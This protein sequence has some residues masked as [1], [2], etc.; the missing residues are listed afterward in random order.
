[1]TAE[2]LSTAGDAS[3]SV[4]TT[5]QSLVGKLGILSLALIVACFAVFCTAIP[6][7]VGLQALGVRFFV[8]DGYVK[9]PADLAVLELAGVPGDQIELRLL[10]SESSTGFE[11]S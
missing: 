5:T 6:V 10:K 11:R 9:P 4:I 7:G 2:T 3:G 1:M 8:E